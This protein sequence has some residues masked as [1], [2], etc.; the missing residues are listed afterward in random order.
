MNIYRKAVN[1][2][3][4]AHLT[5]FFNRQID[6]RVGF[7]DE[8]QQEVRQLGGTP[9]TD[10]STMGNLHRTWIDFKTALSFDKEESMLDSCITGERNCIE[11]YNDMLEEDNL[12]VSIRTTLTRQKN[13]VE[14]AL[15]EVKMAEE[16]RD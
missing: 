5:S 15:R 12:P 3:D 7:I 2:V 9:S 16:R 1:K 13:A 11:E 14:A 8:L 10:S 4:D 6:Q